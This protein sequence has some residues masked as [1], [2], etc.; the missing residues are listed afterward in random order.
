MRKQFTSA[1]RYIQM[2]SASRMGT[3]HPH[4]LANSIPKSGT[5][6]VKAILEG[7]GYQFAGHYN[8]PELSWLT[9]TDTPN[10]MFSTAHTNL[11]VTGPG[12]RMLVFRDPADVAMSWVLYAR[13]RFDHP[14]HKVLSQMSVQQGVNVVFD[15]SAG[16][17][18]LATTYGNMLDWARASDAIGV[19]FGDFKQDPKSLFDKLGDTQT[20]MDAITQAM[21]KWNPT[22]RTQKDPQ[23]AEIKAELR[24]SKESDVVKTYEIYAQMRDM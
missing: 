7:G 10:R 20:D 5:H 14:Q 2:L 22:K 4:I 19:D 11:P 21:G 15:G 6:L 23:E 9:M 12:M 16:I 13:S 18:A 24:A 3:R 8:S 1:R 17:Q